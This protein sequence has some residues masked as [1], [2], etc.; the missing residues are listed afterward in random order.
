MAVPS[1]RCTGVIETIPLSRLGTPEDLGKAPLF[2]AS[3]ESAYI[4]G[5][6]LDVDGGAAQF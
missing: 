6:E 1:R 5:I 4:T 2:L 3:D